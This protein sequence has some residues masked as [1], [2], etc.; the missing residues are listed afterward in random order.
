MHPI[1][2]LTFSCLALVVLVALSGQAF[3]GSSVTVGL[4]AGPGIHYL[5][6]QSA[7]TAVPAGGTVR[8]CP[9]TYPEQMSI[10][11]N[12][13]L[14]G[15]STGTSDAV[16]NV[17]P[18][19][20]LNNTFDFDHPSDLIA[21]QVLVTSGPVSISN[22]TVDGIGN[23]ITGC[24]F[25]LQGIVFQNASGTVNHVAV[26]NQ[27]PGGSLSG[28][29]YGE[30]IYVQTASGYFSTVTVENSSV[31]NYEKNGIT[32]NDSGTTLN[33]TGSYVQGAGALGSGFDAQNGIQL[34]S[35]AVGTIR[36]NTV[37][38]N[39]Y[40]GGYYG[41]A[42]ILLYDV[43]ENSGLVYVESNIVGNS[44][45]PIGLETDTPGTFGDGVYVTN[46]KIFGTVA[47]DGIDV[48]TN[49]NVVTGNT[50][51]NSADSGVHLDATCGGTGINNTVTGNTMLESECAG[52]LDDTNG[53][54]GNTTSPDTYLTVPFPV[55]NLT[56]S[57]V[58][59]GAG[60]V[61]AKSPLKVSPKK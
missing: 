28:G 20:M 8:V 24:A 37:I 2:N 57:C 21:A 42:D 19:P 61:R 1:R 54:G 14:I 52:I 16:V 26:R 31:H 23:G 29:C 59:P 17:P 12:L 45:Y 25:D 4:C 33:V 39:S 11:K 49:N 10:N 41:A 46:N 51:F 15:V 50:I 38:D 30:S 9:G 48:C 58:L 35:G 7:V 60:P 34:G 55:A 6:I 36:G 44:Q 43:A 5:T 53:S 40:T 22:L 27:I 3:A 32:G 18:T 56:T 13:T 47:W